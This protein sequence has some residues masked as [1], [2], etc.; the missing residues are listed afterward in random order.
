M[1]LVDAIENGIH[2]IKPGFPALI[3]YT[4]RN[5]T[6]Q[7]ASSMAANFDYTVLQKCHQEIKFN[8]YLKKEKY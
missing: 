3:F 1:K 8:I 4:E 5:P 2:K 7:N 6:E